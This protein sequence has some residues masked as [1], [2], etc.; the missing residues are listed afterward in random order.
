MV[1]YL[2]TKITIFALRLDA[3]IQSNSARR[4]ISRISYHI[5]CVASKSIFVRSMSSSSCENI[6][7][8]IF[9]S[10]ASIRFTHSL[11]QDNAK[12][13]RRRTMNK[14]QKAAKNVSNFDAGGGRRLWRDNFTKKKKMKISFHGKKMTEEKRDFAEHWNKASHSAH[15]SVFA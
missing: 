11:M 12:I 14:R 1:M 6:L 3:E 8:L 10:A 9:Q 4:T 2:W 13:R 15:V 5:T 7:C